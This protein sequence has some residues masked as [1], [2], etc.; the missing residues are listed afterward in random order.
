MLDY[1]YK[2]FVNLVETKSYTKTAE[3]INFTQPAVTKHIQYIEKELNVQLVSY[4]NRKLI[5]TDEGLYLYEKIK[6]IIAEID[7][8]KTDFNQKTV[9]NIGASKT[10]GEYLLC[11]SLEIYK[12]DYP[13]TEISLYVD[14]TKQLIHS[15]KKRQIDIALISGPVNDYSLR[16]EKFCHD[17]IILICSPKHPLANKTIN[18][19][20]IYPSTVYIR[21]KGAGSLESLEQKLNELNM[22]ISDIPKLYTVGNINLIKSFVKNNN[23]ISFVYHSSVADDIKSGTLSTININR[24][25]AKQDF[26][27]VSNNEQTITQPAKIFLNEL[28]YASHK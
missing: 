28:I 4:K 11:K 15:L 23:G 5:I 8:I 24:F 20:D 10:I 12:K 3:L 22:K 19:Q 27:I 6:R 2:T 14:N 17:T 13:N 21:E 16:R 18:I 9:L 1:R 26:Y 7:K 25:H